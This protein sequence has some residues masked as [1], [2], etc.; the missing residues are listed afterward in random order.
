[1]HEFRVT[2]YDPQYRVNGAYTRNEWTSFADVGRNYAGRIFTPAEYERAEKQH[3]DFLCELADRC[4]AFPLRVDGY[5]VHYRND[6]WQDGQAI[7]RKELPDII[8]A[9]LREECWCR[10][11]GEGFFIHFGYEYYVYVGCGLPPETV[12]RMAEAYGLFCEAF[13]SPYLDEEAT[14]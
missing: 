8:R 9:N 4:G 7:G 5:D 6:A 13:C 12:R 14:P 1:M 10:L 2:K 11:V 3:I